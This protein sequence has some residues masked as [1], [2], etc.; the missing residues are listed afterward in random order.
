VLKSLDDETIAAG[1]HAGKIVLLHFWSY[2][3]EPFPPEPYGQVGYLDFLHNRRQQRG[4]KV[5]GI[6]VDHRL[7]DKT[8]TAAVV[9]S[10]RKLQAFMNLSYPL[11]LDDGSLLA[12]FGDPERVGAK[13]PL[14]VLID[15]SG[16]IV[17]YKLGNYDIKADEGLSQLDKTVLSLLRKQRKSAAMK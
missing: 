13:L 17:E 7:T 3:G 10:I 9:R 11:T 8:Q 4:V 6:A 16:T 14:W 5:Y 1:Q 12:R 15:Q 2:Q